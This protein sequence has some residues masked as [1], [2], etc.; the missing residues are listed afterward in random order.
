[1]TLIQMSKFDQPLPVEVLRGF[2]GYCTETR[3][4]GYWVC[5]MPEHEDQRHYLVHR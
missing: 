4:D 2:G 5:V 1:M 3:K